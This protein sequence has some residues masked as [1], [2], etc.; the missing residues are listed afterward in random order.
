[1]QETTE[2]KKRWRPRKET[3]N[4]KWFDNKVIK[5]AKWRP[6]KMTEETKKLLLFAFSKSYSDE[7]ACLYAGI[8]KL[9][10]YRY[11][12]QDPEFWERKELLKKLPTLKAKLVWISKIEEWNYQASKERLERKAREEFWMKNWIE[13]NIKLNFSIPD[14][15]KK[16]LSEINEE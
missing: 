8:S 2:K 6:T 5:R 12:E 10:L 15:G 9:T 4:L 13:Q 1:M 7:E 3:L 14:E 11:I 16:L